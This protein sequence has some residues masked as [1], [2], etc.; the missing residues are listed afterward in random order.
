MSAAFS[1]TPREA[2][3]L[4]VL[5]A[6][7]ADSGVSPSFDEIMVGLGVSSKSGVH[8]VLSQLERKGRI[9]REYHK[10]RSIKILVPL[11]MGDA[12]KTVDRARL[13]AALRKAAD[14]LEAVPA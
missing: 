2:D 5:Q 10:P 13:I 12:K 7:I 1:L 8:R 4:A 14:R 11:K 6:A 9:E 3:C